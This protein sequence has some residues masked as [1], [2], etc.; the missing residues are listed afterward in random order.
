MKRKSLKLA[1]SALSVVLTVGLLAGCGAKTQEKTETKTLSGSITAAGSTALQPL[2]EKA[3]KNFQDK[4]SGVTITVQGGG[5]G[6][7]LTQVSQGSIDIGNSDI[8]AEDK[9]KDDAK[10]LVDHIVCISG[11]VIAVSSDVKVDNLTKAQVKDIFSGKVTNWKQ[12]GGD[13]A[14]INVIHRPASS[15]TRATF[16]KTVLDGDAAGENDQI[17]TTQD[18]NGAVEKSLESTKGAITYLALSYLKSA[19]GKINTVKLDGVEATKENITSKKYPFYSDEHM[20][21]KGE[22]NEVTKAFLDYMV[23]ADNKSAIED[24]GYIPVTK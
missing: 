3:G 5:S 20:Y 2:V 23:S 19:T 16:V 4:N 14:P 8:A 7:G 12:V 22:P 1:I 17:G 15:G 10:S 11:F 24:L 9:L 6:T 18:S 13:D 21:T